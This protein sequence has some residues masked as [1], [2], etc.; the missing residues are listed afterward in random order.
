MKGLLKFVVDQ[1]SEH[2]PVGC[3]LGYV[4]D[5]DVDSAVSKVRATI[6]ESGQDLALVTVPQDEVA[7]GE[8]TRFSS[9]HRRRSNGGEIEVR[10]ALL[11]M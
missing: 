9:R 11:P 1:Y 4:L 2:L 8:A 5:G 7:I 3:M 6:V 10:H